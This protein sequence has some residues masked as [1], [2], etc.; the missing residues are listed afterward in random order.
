[1]IHRGH[2]YGSFY[3]TIS[4]QQKMYVLVEEPEE[5]WK[6]E[7]NCVLDKVENGRAGTDALVAVR[8]TEVTLLVESCDPMDYVEGPDEHSRGA[9]ENLREAV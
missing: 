9:F 7:S 6:N 1:M 3:S 8:E 2:Q 5:F 4:L